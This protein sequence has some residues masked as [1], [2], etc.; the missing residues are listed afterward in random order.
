M[1]KIEYIEEEYHLEIRF[2]D[3][4]ENLSEIKRTIDDI[5]QFEK[6]FFKYVAS[7]KK[8]DYPKN[9]NM[10]VIKLSKQSPL[11]ITLAISGIA[12]SFFFFFLGDYGNDWKTVKKL[13]VD[14]DR[15]KKIISEKFKIYGDRWDEEWDEFLDRIEELIVWFNKQT[16][17]KRYKFLTFKNKL[18]RTLRAIRE[19][20]INKK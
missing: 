4:I 18:S 1:K 3:E 2:Q 8:G 17:E 9:I 16:I 12:L 15:L 6:E 13:K 20:W 14:R 7:L 19:I 10:K 11:E 5:E